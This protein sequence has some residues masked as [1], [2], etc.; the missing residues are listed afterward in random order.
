M[1]IK[2][3]YNVG[4]RVLRIYTENERRRIK[5][6]MCEGK[7][8]ITV[9]KITTSC[10]NCSG[11]G[12]ISEYRNARHLETRTEITGIKSEVGFSKKLTILYYLKNG[13]YATAENLIPDGRITSKTEKRLIPEKWHRA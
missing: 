5:C 1:I 6:P 10:P 7:Q 12:E 13:Y 9:N 3:K 11:A 8:E 4:D 2:T